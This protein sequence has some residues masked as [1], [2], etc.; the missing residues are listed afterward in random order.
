MLS[1]GNKQKIWRY[2]MKKRLFDE[3]IKEFVPF[4]VLEAS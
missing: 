4:A 3:E 2:L 1:R